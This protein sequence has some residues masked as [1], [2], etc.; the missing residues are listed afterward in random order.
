MPYLITDLTGHLEIRPNHWMFTGMRGKNGLATIFGRGR[1]DQVGPQRRKVDLT[2][3]AEH[4]AFDKPLRAALL[5]NWQGTWDILNPNGSSHVE[6]HV[7]VEPGKRDH[8]HLTIVPDPET[9]VQL[10]L[11]PAPGTPVVARG[12]KIRLPPMEDV[13]GTFIY[14]DGHVSMAGV[15]FTFREA[16]VSFRDGSATFFDDNRFELAVHDL[17]VSNLRLDSDLRRVMPPLMAEFARRLDD[18]RPFRLHSDLGIG[19]SG[20]PNQ[21]AV[22]TWEKATAAFTGNTIRAGLP[23]GQIHG[24]ASAVHGRSDGRTLVVSGVLDIDSIE[25]AGQQVTRLTTPFE[26]GGGWAKFHEIGADLLGGKVFGRA[27]ISLE[28]TPRYEAYVKVMGA[29][30]SQYTRTIPGRQGI[31]GLVSGEARFKGQGND[32]RTLSG[33]GEAHIEQGELGKLPLALQLLKVLHLSPATK[34]AFDSAHVSFTVQDGLGTLNPIKFIGDAFSL[35][36]SGTIDPLGT[37]DLTLS[38][39]LYGR[40]DGRRV[41]I[42]T[43]AKNMVR[44]ATSRVL[45]VHVHGPA[46]IP[47]F[48]AEVLPGPTERA[49]E[50]FQRIGDRR[51]G[52]DERR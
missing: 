40:T 10:E 37:L 31:R 46:T 42:L 35:Q 51:S 15:T 34:T 23:L 21:P 16:P 9:R 12:G 24:Q 2:L 47:K 17:E 48:D 20:D 43:D 4:L 25:V 5:K 13:K 38:A 28:D 45:A 22:C 11:T 29:D 41:P 44:E 8:C 32:L 30:L 6:A 3:E 33:E 39:V 19:W 36:G 18:G 52:K 26:V 1:V 14:D 27:A 50:L 7:K 49:A